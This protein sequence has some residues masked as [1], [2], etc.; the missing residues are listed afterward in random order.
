MDIHIAGVGD[1]M[2][3]MRSRR[4]S[5][6]EAEIHWCTYSCQVVQTSSDLVLHKM[7][8]GMAMSILDRIERNRALLRVRSARAVIEGGMVRYELPGQEKSS[9]PSTKNV[10]SYLIRTNWMKPTEQLRSWRN[11]L[12]DNRYEK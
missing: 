8:G 4:R 5:T 12:I 7:S 3:E 9:Q 6:L 10:Q 11:L 2:R 1:E